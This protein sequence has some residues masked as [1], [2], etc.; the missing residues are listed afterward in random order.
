MFAVGDYQNF[1][2][3]ATASIADAGSFGDGDA[4]SY[5]VAFT[6]ATER[7]GEAMV[8][9][10]AMGTVTR[11]T[12][13]DAITD[14]AGCP[15]FVRSRFDPRQLLV[16]PRP[17]DG[18]SLPD[19]CRPVSPL[20]AGRGVYRFADSGAPQEGVFANGARTATLTFVLNA[21][22]ELVASL[23]TAQGPQLGTAASLFERLRPRDAIVGR[24]IE[25]VHALTDCRVAVVLGASTHHVEQVGGCPQSG[26]FDFAG[27]YTRP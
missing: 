18:G 6:F 2:G 1:D 26:A 16:L 4:G 15:V 3:I 17:D 10:A 12:P 27:E 21:T 11:D 19:A 25:L 22:G 24:R 7:L 5:T 8:N 20:F 23:A 9:T 14:V 13:G